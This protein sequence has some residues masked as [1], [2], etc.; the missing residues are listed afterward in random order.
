MV[1]YYGTTAGLILLDEKVTSKIKDA[2]LDEIFF[3]LTPV[4]TVV[5]PD[6]MTVGACDRSANRTGESWQAVLSH[7]P[8]LRYVI[9]DEAK[10]IGK[11]VRLTNA[12]LLHQKDLYHLMR[13]ISKTTRRLEAREYTLL[14][15]EEKAW[16]DWIKGCIYTKTMEKTLA[17]VNRQLE[18]M[19]QYYQSLELLDFAFSPL[20]KDC[21]VNTREHGRMNPRMKSFLPIAICGKRS[22]P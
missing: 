18:L 15:A 2:C 14:K 5:E 13:E 8:N 7:F 4:L 1:Q 11:G 19:E 22:E 20:T 16:Q 10:G 21:K 12:T 9:S 17:T 3:H 6:S